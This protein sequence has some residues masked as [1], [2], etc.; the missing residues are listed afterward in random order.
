MLY[1]PCW[2][3]LYWILDQ[4]FHVKWRNRWVKRLFL[5]SS[6]YFNSYVYIYI[7]IIHI[8][9]IH[10]FMC[11]FPG[12]LGY[13]RF[14]PAKLYIVWVRLLWPGFGGSMVILLW[15]FLFKA[16]FCW[17]VPTKA[18]GTTCER[19]KPTKHARSESGQDVKCISKT[20]GA[21]STY[22]NANGAGDSMHVKEGSQ[23]KEVIM[24]ECYS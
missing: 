4:F 5:S 13:D 2:F 11:F 20:T 24:Q 3:N 23:G 21:N 8:Y 19:L 17:V 18:S 12:R 14:T 15:I 9:L 1:N 7:Y 22:E 10:W 16:L 6:V